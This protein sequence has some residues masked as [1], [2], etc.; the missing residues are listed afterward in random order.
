MILDVRANRGERHTRISGGGFRFANLSEAENASERTFSCCSLQSRLFVFA[1]LLYDFGR[2]QEQQEEQNN[3]RAAR[4]D[5]VVKQH[6]DDDD[7]ATRNDDGRKT[8]D[9]AV[10]IYN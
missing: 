1:L 2:K 4:R 7:D 3:Q 10:I 6:D 5:G 9:E 8:E